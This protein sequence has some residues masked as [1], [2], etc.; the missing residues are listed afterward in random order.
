MCFHRVSG[1]C[2]GIR[3]VHQNQP[4]EMAKS[5]LIKVDFIIG[6]V[7]EE[8]ARDAIEWPVLLLHL[9]PGLKLYDRNICRGSK[10][11]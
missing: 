10:L 8:I 3:H 6:L 5:K 9:E 2:S 11:M 1:Y 4:F 7:P